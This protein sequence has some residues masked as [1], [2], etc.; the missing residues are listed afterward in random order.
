M[1]PANIRPAIRIK[2]SPGEYLSMMT[3]SP[4]AETVCSSKEMPIQTEVARPIYDFE[5]DSMSAVVIRMRNEE[6][7]RPISTQPM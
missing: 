6:F 1:S 3:P 5:T 2:P 4:V 7:V